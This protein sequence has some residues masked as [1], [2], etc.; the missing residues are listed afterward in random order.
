M[1]LSNACMADTIYLNAKADPYTAMRSQECYLSGVHDIEINN[2]HASDH[3]YQYLYQLCTD[4]GICHSWSGDISV[5]A[6]GKWNGHHDSRLR[7]YFGPGMHIL[8]AHTV[9]SGY[10]YQDTSS[11]NSIVIY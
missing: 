9:V 8:T 4:N 3:A 10:Q 7:A 11:Y 5:K 1:L 6:N 2:T